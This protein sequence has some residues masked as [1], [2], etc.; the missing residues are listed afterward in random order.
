MNILLGHGLCKCKL[1]NSI[2]SA[3]QIA[4]NEKNAILDNFSNP[5]I[6]RFSHLNPEIHSELRFTKGY[7]QISGCNL[8]KNVVPT[9][10]N[11]PSALTSSL[12]H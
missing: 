9:D 11:M 4:L 3:V 7:Q 8:V 6:L 2:V 5:G 10:E 1:N 12:R